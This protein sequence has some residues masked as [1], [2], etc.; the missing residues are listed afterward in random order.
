MTRKN[1]SPTCDDVQMA[2]LA[3]LDGEAAALPPE[4]IDRHIADCSACRAAVAEFTTL[5]AALGRVDYA[6]RDDDLWPAV[7]ARASAI[8]SR[9][10]RRE[11]GAILGLAAALGAWRLAQLL[12][13]LPAPVV[14]SLLPLAVMAFVL[15]RV[16]GD[17]FAIRVTPLQLE[18][19]GVS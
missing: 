11:R 18:G 4:D 7:R 13:D 6:Q 2:A 10:P 15:W 14:N 8:P 3:R 5:H 12:L 16:T 17:P 1:S 9:T 19:K